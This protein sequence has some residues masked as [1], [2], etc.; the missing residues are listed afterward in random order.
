M[1][2]KGI[3]IGQTAV[4]ITAIRDAMQSGIIAAMARGTSYTIAGRSFSFPGLAEAGNMIQEANY[5]LGLL[6]G[7]RSQVVRANFNDGMGRYS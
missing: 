2:A 5:A 4:E 6:N 7:S 1:A 3:F